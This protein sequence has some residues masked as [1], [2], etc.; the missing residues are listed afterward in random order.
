[1]ANPLTGTVCRDNIDHRER[2][3]KPICP[4]FFKQQHSDCVENFSLRRETGTRWLFCFGLEM[5]HFGLSLGIFGTCTLGGAG[6][7]A[8]RWWSSALRHQGVLP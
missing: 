4:H 2:D 8:R 7:G 3:T 6:V 1:M 5:A